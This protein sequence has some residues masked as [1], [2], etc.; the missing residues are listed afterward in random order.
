M[1]AMKRE[2]LVYNSSIEFL[3][4]VM[5]RDPS[6]VQLLCPHC[7]AELIFAPTWEAAN[8]KKVHPGIYC[9]TDKRHV[10]SMFELVPPIKE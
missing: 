9:P 5:D 2:I 7:E 8:A 4:G 3:M 1:N 6:S 10:S